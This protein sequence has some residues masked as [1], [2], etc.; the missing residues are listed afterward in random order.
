MCDKTKS[1]NCDKTKQKIQFQQNQPT[2]K[3]FNKKKYTYLKT[4]SV[5]KY[6]NC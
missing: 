1:A 6:K 3:F 5:A 2:L 4:Q